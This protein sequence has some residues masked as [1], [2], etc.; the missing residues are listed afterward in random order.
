M[1]SSGVGEAV[2]AHSTAGAAAGAEGSR[3]APAPLLPERIVRFIIQF[4][5]FIH[6]T[7][8]CAVHVVR[9]AADSRFLLF[10]SFY[11]FKYSLSFK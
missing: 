2:A 4:I 10:I 7:S 3:K 1:A 11:S 9:L 6:Y 8:F 5:F